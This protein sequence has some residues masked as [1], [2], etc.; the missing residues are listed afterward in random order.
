MAT[1]SNTLLDVHVDRRS[2]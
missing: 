1:V 2:I